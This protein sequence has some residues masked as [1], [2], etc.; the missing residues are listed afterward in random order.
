VSLDMFRELACNILPGAGLPS[1]HAKTN[2][3]PGRFFEKNKS[4]IFR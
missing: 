3:D 1:L 4:P 2:L